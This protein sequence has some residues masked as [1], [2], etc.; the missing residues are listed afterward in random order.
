MSCIDLSTLGD[1]ICILGPSSSGKSTLAAAIG[2]RHGHGIVHLDQ[3]HH[4]PNTDWVP[5]PKA[6]FVALHDDAISQEKWV[7]E[8]NYSATLGARLA[9]ATGVI[10]LEMP[11]A[12]NVLRYVR[13]SLSH[14]KRSG[15]LLGGN[16]RMKCFMI[17]YIVH[18][19]PK[20]RRHQMTAISKANLP[21]VHMRSMR[22]MRG[23]YREWG[24]ER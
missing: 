15:G 2:R 4:A 17:K 8:G 14:T 7:I 16:D 21:M 20:S 9:R 19:Q 23:Y 12:G 10:L 3:L 18:V 11:R 13:R 5:R 22:E 24:L 1:R 6:E